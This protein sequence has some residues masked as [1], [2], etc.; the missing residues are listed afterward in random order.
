MNRSPV[1]M[2]TWTGTS[3]L[4]GCGRLIR[5]G[6]LA[7]YSETP[8]IPSWV[9]VSAGWPGRGLMPPA[10]PAAEHAAPGQLGQDGELE[11]DDVPG[12]GELA[13]EVGGA[14]RAAQHAAAQPGAGLVDGGPAHRG[15]RGH[16]ARQ[17]GR[18]DRLPALQRAP[19]VTDQVHRPVRAHLLDH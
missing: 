1:A 10:P 2:T 12:P 5:R 7:R 4:A 16:P 17:P 18:A 19:V 15:E 8:F 14:P 3:T 6:M 9:M 11:E 13:R